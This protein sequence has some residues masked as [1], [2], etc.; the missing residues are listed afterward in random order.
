MAAGAGLVVYRF[1]V[2][3]RDLPCGHQRCRG[4]K[5]KNCLFHLCLLFGLYSTSIWAGSALRATICLF[6]APCA[7]RLIWLLAQSSEANVFPDGT[8]AYTGRFDI[9][10]RRWTRIGK[11]V[12]RSAISSISGSGYP[13]IAE[14]PRIGGIDVIRIKPGA[15]GERRPVR[16]GA[17]QFA[18]IGHA[19]LE[20][21]PVVEFVG[22][23]YAG[24]GISQRPDDRRREGGV[25]LQAGGVVE[26]A[27][28]ARFLDAQLRAEPVGA[29]LVAHQQHPQLV[30]PGIDF[31]AQQALLRREAP[32]VAGELVQ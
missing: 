4:S 19:K 17:D 2:G 32:A 24:L 13:E 16:I 8:C 3:S 15:A 28:L 12:G 22:L 6:N 18:Q 31:L 20:D 5:N 7:I 10:R 21:R 23:D 11:P 30:E 27:Q 26:R 29:A 1:T 25:Y 14:L 9:H